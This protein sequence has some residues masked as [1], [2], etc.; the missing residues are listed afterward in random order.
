M[1]L[2]ETIIFLRSNIKNLYANRDAHKFNKQFVTV[3]V[4][5]NADFIIIILYM[6]DMLFNNNNTSQIAQRQKK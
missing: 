6:V 1:E 3:N 5:K 2:R 4:N